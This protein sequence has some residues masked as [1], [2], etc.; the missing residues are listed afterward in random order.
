MAHYSSSHTSQVQSGKEESSPPSA[1][2]LVLLCV[3]ARLPVLTPFFI[4]FLLP[5]P[6]ILYSL[7]A[8]PH[9]WV[10][11]HISIASWLPL[12]PTW[13]PLWCSS[14]GVRT[15]GCI[16]DV[17]RDL[18]VKD[19][20]RGVIVL[21]LEPS[22]AL[23]VRR[24][25]PLPLSSYSAI[26]PIFT[27][28]FLL[29]CKDCVSTAGLPP[30]S[31]CLDCDGAGRSS[32]WLWYSTQKS[33][34]RYYSTGTMWSQAWGCNWRVWSMAHRGGSKSRQMD[35]THHLFLFQ[36]HGWARRSHWQCQFAAPCIVLL[37]PASP[38]IHILVHLNFVLSSPLRDV[39]T[40]PFCTTQGHGLSHPLQKHSSA[41]AHHPWGHV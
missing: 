14:L 36:R 18:G 33:L 2:S 12:D 16:Q 17:S 26:S 21:P 31:I 10:L 40:H 34:H 28:H 35:A 41:G 27:C 9:R 1:F 32:T 8:S 37:I 7:Y 19:K 29:S 15:L 30:I 5:I 11:G 23:G 24:C 25:P 6:L 4:A 20:E 3:L 22:E 38:N 39:C 13:K